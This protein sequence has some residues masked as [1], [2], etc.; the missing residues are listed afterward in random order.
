MADNIGYGMGTSF[1]EKNRNKSNFIDK[2]Y[3]RI[4]LSI[5]CAV[6]ST[7]CGA[8]ISK[9]DDT[10]LTNVLIILTGIF[11]IIQG[12]LS[13]RWTELDRA[14]E[15]NTLEMEKKTSVYK[16]LFE[17]LPYL[18]DKQAEGLNKISKDIIKNGII[19]G[20]RWTFDDASTL[21]CHSIRSFLKDYCNA[22]CNVYYVRTINDEGNIVKMVGCANDLGNVPSIYM[23]ER[24]VTVDRNAYYDIRMFSRRNLKAEYRLTANDVDKVFNYN[25]REKDSGHIEQFLFIPISCDKRKMIGLVEI[26]VPKGEHMVDSNDEMVNIQKLLKIYSSIFVLLNIAEKAAMAQP[27]KSNLEHKAL[28]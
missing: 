24:P 3:V 7:V 11:I 14:R 28:Q 23:I 10:M 2:K 12:A 4:I 13:Y 18:L 1:T 8:L 25:D 5:I 22:S 15:I 26:I 27:H 6:V 21:V 16:K 9:F 19:P 17:E 20:D